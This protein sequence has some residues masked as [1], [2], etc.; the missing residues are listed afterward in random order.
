MQTNLTAVESKEE[1]TLSKKSGKGTSDG[2]VSELTM[3]YTVK[4]GHAEQLRAAIQRHAA[5]FLGLD[6]KGRMKTGIREVR[7]A[8]FDNDQ[9]L[10]FCTSFESDWDAYIDDVI[11][12]AGVDIYTEIFRHL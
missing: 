8:L 5:Y 9:R 1:I 4:P 3:F 7:M 11:E 10:L 6:R 12:F 2:V